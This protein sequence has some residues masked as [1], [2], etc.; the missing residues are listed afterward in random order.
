M[1]TLEFIGSMF[2]LIVI[3]SLIMGFYEAHK[4]HKK[5]WGNSQRRDKRQ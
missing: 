5:I 2:L 1:S 3:V 4:E